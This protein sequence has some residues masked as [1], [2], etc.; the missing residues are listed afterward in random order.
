MKNTDPAIDLT[1][2]ELPSDEKLNRITTSDINVNSG[3]K[4]RRKHQTDHAKRQRDHYS[5][6]SHVMEHKNHYACVSLAKRGVYRL[7]VYPV[8]K[9]PSLIHYESLI[10]CKSRIDA[11]SIAKLIIDQKYNTLMAE[12]GAFLL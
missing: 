8:E 1:D 4:V 5:C 10:Q 7:V 6:V 12:V 9:D 11:W 2:I 3:L